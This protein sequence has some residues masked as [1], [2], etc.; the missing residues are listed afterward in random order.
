MQM[1]RWS[2]GNSRWKCETLGDLTIIVEES[3]EEYTFEEWKQNR[4]MSTCKRLDLGSLARILSD[5]I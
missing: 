2:L 1:K 5:Y 4:K 3:M